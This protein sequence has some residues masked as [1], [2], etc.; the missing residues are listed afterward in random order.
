MSAK[1]LLD[2]I[3][4]FLESD[5]VTSVESK[6]LLTVAICRLALSVVPDIQTKIYEHIVAA[7]IGATVCE[8][9]TGPD[10]ITADNQTMEVK[11]THVTLKTKKNNFAWPVPKGTTIDE[12]IGRA[13]V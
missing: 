3:H 8:K 7:E 12:K 11:M 1:D 4:R 2:A 10:L 5:E 9:L 13:H 6:K